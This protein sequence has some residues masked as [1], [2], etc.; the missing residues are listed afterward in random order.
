MSP[1]VVINKRIPKVSLLDYNVY[2]EHDLLF[3]FCKSS[4][5]SGSGASQPY[6]AN[7]RTQGQPSLNDTACN[8]NAK[9]SHCCGQDSV[10][11]DNGFCL[12]AGNIG[13]YVVSRGSCTDLNFEEPCGQRCKDV[14]EEGGTLLAWVSPYPFQYCCLGFD[15]GSGQCFQPTLGASTPFNI[16][17]GNVIHDRSTGSAQSVNASQVTASATASSQT[18]AIGATSSAVYRTDKAHDA[19]IGAG[20]GVSLGV[21]LLAAFVAILILIRQRNKSRREVIALQASMHLQSFRSPSDYKPP[22]DSHQLA[23]TP[24]AEAP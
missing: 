8:A 5:T 6:S 10:C 15:V 9:V 21:S 12:E 3:S 20:I 18:S 1:I 11:L 19:A 4:S 13:P 23:G 14:Q 22:F 7:G 2:I 17:P 16:T 24:V